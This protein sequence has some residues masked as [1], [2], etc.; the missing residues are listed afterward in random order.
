MNRRR[1]CV[2]VADGDSRSRENLQ[3]HLCDEGFHVL[4]AAGGSDTLLQCEVELPSVLIMDARFPDMDGYEV[5]ERLRKDSLGSD[6]TIIM[7]VE[8]DDEM[9]RAYAGQ[10][11]D[12]AGGDFFLTKPYDPGLVVTLLHSLTRARRIDGGATRHALK[13]SVTGSSV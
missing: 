6:I 1:N 2:L 13:T 3:L 8:P 7:L 4:T 12:F 5:C 11:V 10:M 9:T